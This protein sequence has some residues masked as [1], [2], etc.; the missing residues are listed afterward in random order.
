MSYCRHT[1]KTRKREIRADKLCLL[2]GLFP[3]LQ[4]DLALVALHL[5]VFKKPDMAS[6]ISKKLIGCTGWSLPVGSATALLMGI[7]NN[8][9]CIYTPGYKVLR[10]ITMQ[11]IVDEHDSLPLLSARSTNFSPGESP[12]I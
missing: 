1:Q 10:S 3:I 11:A 8:Q 6:R 4:Y 2:F 7:W 5:S 12:T 9:G